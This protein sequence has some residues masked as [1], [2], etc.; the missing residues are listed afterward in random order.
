VHRALRIVDGHHDVAQPQFRLHK[1]TALWFEA[2]LKFEHLWLHCHHF[3]FSFMIFDFSL[4]L[5]GDDID[6]VGR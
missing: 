1:F 6:G 5:S 4:F 2:L 3:H